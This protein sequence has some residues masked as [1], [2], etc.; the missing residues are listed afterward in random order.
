MVTGIE[1]I[2]MGTTVNKNTVKKK[3]KPL[4]VI[5][6]NAIW[7]LGVLLYTTNYLI[8]IVDNVYLLVDWDTYFGNNSVV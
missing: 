3:E 7:I 5:I 4:Y 1:L 6:L 8:F 2:T